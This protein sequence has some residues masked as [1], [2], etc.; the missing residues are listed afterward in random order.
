MKLIDK[1]QERDNK[2]MSMYN[3]LFGKNPD[4][5]II[6]KM[7]G[8]TEE[9][10]GRFRD[11]YIEDENIIVFTRLGGGNRECY[12]DTDE[13][14]NSSDSGCYQHNIEYLQ[15]NTNYVK[16]YDDGF[17]E[18]YA[19][20]VYNIPEQ[21]KELAKKYATKGENLKEKFDSIIEEMKSKSKEELKSDPRFSQL[22]DICDTIEADG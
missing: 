4:R 21:F 3:M 1:R 11:C 18:T 7:I 13:E 16:D 10:C 9:A 20:F 17:D 12:C 5:N 6:L 15:A 2:T 14:H 22:V 8:I 19:Y